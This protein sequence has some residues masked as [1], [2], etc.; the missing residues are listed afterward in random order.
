MRPEGF[1][2][3]MSS[4]RIPTEAL[5]ARDP[6]PPRLIPISDPARL[7]LSCYEAIRAPIRIR[8]GE[9]VD[10]Q[11]DVLQLNAVRDALRARVTE[12]NAIE[13]VRGQP[14]T[15]CSD[16]FLEARVLDLVEANIRANGNVSELPL[17]E[18]R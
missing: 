10:R 3:W 16:P 9:I 18:W 1:Q 5:E 2:D 17:E 8:A 15:L 4:P 13:A 7:V 14:G 11:E 6:G 12:T